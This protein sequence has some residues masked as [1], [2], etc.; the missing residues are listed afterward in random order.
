[1]KKFISLILVLAM[2]LCM[3]PG[4]A[5][6]ESGTEWTEYKFDAV[7]YDSKMGTTT[8]T[9][10]EVVI[11][12]T[13]VHNGTKYRVTSLRSGAFHSCTSLES[14]VIPNSVKSIGHGAFYH[15]SSLKSITIPKGVTTIS[16]LAFAECSSLESIVIPDGVT[17]IGGNAF[18][19]CTSLTSITIPA[20]VVSIGNSAFLNCTNLTTVNYTGTAEQWETLKSI[21]DRG[22]NGSITDMGKENINFNYIII[23]D[24]TLQDKV[25]PTPTSS[26]SGI[27]VTYN[28]G[29]S[30]STSN[31]AVPTGVEIDNVPVSFTGN[32]SNFTVSGIPAGAKWITVRWNSTSV[33]TNFTPNGAYFAEVEIP[34]TGDMSF[35][36]AIAEF[37]GF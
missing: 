17:T 16:T 9:D 5:M 32:G 28:G 36:A 22:G 34:K 10:K 14:I 30:F 11:P 26:G 1:M 8:S 31:P 4:M 33:T 24:D 18:R 12:E 7:D 20:S 25:D 13:F 27:S 3:L 15:C 37:L 35:W 6:A 29:N 23:S 19:D 2:V 21:I